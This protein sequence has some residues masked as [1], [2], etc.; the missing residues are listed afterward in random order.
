MSDGFRKLKTQQPP[1]FL[2]ESQ[3]K[4]FLFLLIF[5]TISNNQ[6]IERVVM[7]LLPTLLYPRKKKDVD[8]IRAQILFNFKK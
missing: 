2:N 8:E 5:L 4:S 7:S 3:K 6:K 1:G